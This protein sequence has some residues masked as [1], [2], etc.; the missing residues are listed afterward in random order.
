V[1]VYTA[2]YGGYDSL[3]DHP[4]HSDVSDWIAYTDNPELVGNDWT[5]VPEPPKYPHPRLAAKWRKCH[6][7][8]IG[9]NTLWVDGS[10][11]IH[12]TDLI[13]VVAAQLRQAPLTMFPHPWR[14]CIYE[15]VG[16][17]VGMAKYAGLEDKMNRQVAHY[18]ENG[19]KD[20]AGL[21]ASTVIGRRDDPQVI[22]HGAAWFAHCETFTYQDQLSLPYLLDRYNITPAPLPYQLHENPWFVWCGHHRDD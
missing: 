2:I 5:I 7:P 9:A 10:V 18:R 3:H 17:S 8:S 14:D 19:W 16:A 13:D 20:H 6:P 11:W 15:E 21:W 1:I 12:N 4:D 22:R